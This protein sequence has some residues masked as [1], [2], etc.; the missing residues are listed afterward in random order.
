M[1]INDLKISTKAQSFLSKS[2][3]Q[4]DTRPELQSVFYDDKNHRLV[5]SNG[6]MLSILPLDDGV[7]VSEQKLQVGKFPVVPEYPDYRLVIPAESEHSVRVKRSDLYRAMKQ[8]V[9]LSHVTDKCTTLMSYPVASFDVRK[10]V[11]DVSYYN[12]EVGDINIT[13]DATLQCDYYLPD[14]FSYTFHLNVGYLLIPMKLFG[15]NSDVIFE[16]QRYENRP[17]LVRSFDSTGFSLIM[18]A[19]A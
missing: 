19:R 9:S 1:H 12:S 4:D 11:I 8:V 17:V 10:G 13:M 18:P 6:Y 7:K 3:Y 15:Q 5:A 2:V 16:L 14:N